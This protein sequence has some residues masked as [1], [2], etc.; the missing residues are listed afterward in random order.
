[1]AITIQAQ[2]AKKVPIPGADY[3]SQ[4]ASITISAEV[5]DLT[6]V[7]TEAQ[8][9]YAIA[10]QAVDA[11]LNRQT[12]AVPQSA[13]SVAAPPQ[14]QP[15][16]GI[17]QPHRPN[18]QRRQPAAVTDSQLRFLK[19]LIDQTKVAVPAILDQYQVGSLDQLSC[20]DAAG[21]IDELKGQ[22]AA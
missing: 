7:V 4:Q 9:I 16:Q 14:A 2:L 20:R 3:S 6:Q 21:L 8:R 5:T 13:R 15:R 10:E 19:R 11:Q 12:A 18:S 22:V 1:M 17:S